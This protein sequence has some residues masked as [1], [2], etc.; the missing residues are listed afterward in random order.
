VEE[1]KILSK[2]I[3]VTNYTSAREQ[4]EN[5]RFGFITEISE[6]GIYGGLKI[7]LDDGSLRLRYSRILSE[8]KQEKNEIF[9]A[10]L[11]PKLIVFLLNCFRYN[12]NPT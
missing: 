8:M 9:L 4:L 12:I 2:P 6:E 5:G 11:L 3:L 7:L 10:N 1:A